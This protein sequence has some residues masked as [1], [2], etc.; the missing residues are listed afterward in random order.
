MPQPNVQC[1]LRAPHQAEAPDVTTD[2][3]LV[4][5]DEMDDMRSVYRKII[6]LIALLFITSLS[7]VGQCDGPRLA[8]KYAASGKVLRGSS[9]LFRLNADY[10]PLPPYPGSLDGGNP[11]LVVIEMAVSAAGRVIDCRMLE[12]FDEKASAAVIS[13]VKSWRFH[14]E[15]EMIASGVLNHCDGCIRINRIAFDFRVDN[16]KRYVLDL[17]Q[18]EIKRR[19]L[20]DPFQV[21]DAKTSVR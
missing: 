19:G 18:Q 10:A 8:L 2:F 4:A 14:T 1:L 17:A 6:G 9:L 11:G 3:C 20:L 13:A 15:K 5:G 16:G 12:T 7:A 21:R